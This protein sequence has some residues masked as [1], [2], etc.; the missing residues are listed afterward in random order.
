[1]GLFATFCLACLFGVVF[2]DL[3]RLWF[4]ERFGHDWLKDAVGQVDRVNVQVL[5]VDVCRRCNKWKRT[6]LREQLK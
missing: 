1:M 4:C 2:Q 5:P 3:I 6:A